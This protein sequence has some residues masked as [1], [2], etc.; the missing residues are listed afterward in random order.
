MRGAVK[1]ASYAKPA[2]NILNYQPLLLKINNQ[3]QELA[4]SSS[5]KKAK[6][7]TICIKNIDSREQANHLI[8]L[9]IY[10]DKSQL[11]SLAKG[12]YYWDELTGF[13]V[14]NQQNITLGKVTGFLDTGANLVLVVGSKKQHYVPYIKHFL[15]SVSVDKKQIL[16]D[17]DEGF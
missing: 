3:W 10:I 13:E 15:I 7:L 16:V 9:D 8:G 2:E 17:W 6:T 4:V 5:I 11:Q 14:I 12:Q 1:I